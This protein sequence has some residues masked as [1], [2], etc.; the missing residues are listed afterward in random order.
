MSTKPSLRTMLVESD[1]C[2]VAIAA[3]L[4][5]SFTTGIKV[6]GPPL[7][8]AFGFVFTAI[9]IRDVPYYDLALSGEDRLEL[10]GLIGNLIACITAAASAWTLSRWSYNVGP[11]RSLNQWANS[12][13][14]S[15][16]V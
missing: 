10:I 15:F 4:V 3:L 11:I 1:I 13:R 9:A 5:R 2:H 14:R 12:L 8:H 6:L 16:H 7:T